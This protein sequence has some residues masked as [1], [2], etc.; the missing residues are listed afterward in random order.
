MQK[1]SKIAIAVAAGAAILAGGGAGVAVAAG[2]GDDSE[3]P[4]T[5]DD[6]DRA[7]AAALEHT[8]GG[9]VTE[10]EVGDE[11][12]L[13]EVEVTLDDGTQVDVQLDEDF[14]VVGDERDSDEGDDADDTDDG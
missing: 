1:R 3:P 4:I 8:G 11:E 10:T 2:G 6:L 14:R 5:G 7:T 9:R 13:Y 12:S